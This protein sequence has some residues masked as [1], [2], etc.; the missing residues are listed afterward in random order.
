MKHHNHMILCAIIAVIAMVAFA[1]SGS[2]PLGAGIGLALLLC[3]LVMGSVM[4]LLMR[5]PTGFA[6]HGEHAHSELRNDPQ[7]ASRAPHP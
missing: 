6:A 7:P 1:T 5:R 4:W 3:P 2:A